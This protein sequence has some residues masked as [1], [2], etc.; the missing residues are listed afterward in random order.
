MGGGINLGG[1]N[2]TG[3]CEVHEYSMGPQ[4]LRVEGVWEG[5]RAWEGD[6]SKQGHVRGMSTGQGLGRIKGSVRVQDSGW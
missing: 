3:A 2:L 5:E 1:D 4:G 6:E